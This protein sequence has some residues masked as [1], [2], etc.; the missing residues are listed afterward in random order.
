MSGRR[1]HDEE[2]LKQVIRE[3]ARAVSY[4]DLINRLVEGELRSVQRQRCTAQQH[5]SRYYSP[6]NDVDMDLIFKIG[7]IISLLY[8][9]F[10]FLS[11][12]LH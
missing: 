11:L 12:F 1:D 10:L 5:V 8:G 6:D 4:A 3:Y 2:V 7:F 9:F